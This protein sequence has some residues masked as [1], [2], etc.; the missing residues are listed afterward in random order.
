M[1][2]KLE[3]NILAVRLYTGEDL[4]SSLLDAFKYT[5]K[6]IGIVLSGVGMMQNVKL[7]YFKGEGRYKEHIFDEPK[8]IVSLTGNVINDGERLYSHLHVSLAD[9]DGR[10]TGGHLIN[11]KVYGTGEIFINLSDIQAKRKKEEETGLEGLKL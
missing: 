11:A 9:E 10:V 2:K 4:V 8:E 1:D 6:P 3:S 5:A 7:G